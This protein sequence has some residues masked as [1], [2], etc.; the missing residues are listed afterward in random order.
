M[1]A[2]I[3]KIAGFFAV[4]VVLCILAVMAKPFYIVN[5]GEQVVISRLKSIVAS[6]TEAGLYFK[7]PFLDKVTVYPKQILSLDGDTQEIQTKEKL[8]IVVDITARWRITDPQ[9]FYQKFQ[10]LE[11]GYNKLS[12]IIDSSCRTIITQNE[13]SEI[14]RSSDIINEKTDDEEADSETEIVTEET[15]YDTVTKGRNELCRQML[16]EANKTSA[17]MGIEII[18]IVPRQIKYTDALTESVYSRM[19]KERNQE[20]QHY[21]STGEGKKAEWLG[22]L[23]NDK[24]TYES[25]AYRK[26]EEIKGNADAEAAKIYAEA[27]NKDPEFYTFWKSMESYKKTLKDYDATYST[28]MDYFDYLYSANGR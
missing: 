26:A 23:E 21:R 16:S 3:K 17:G 20:A 11:N 10:R 27:F 19:I 4:V 25:E 15:I 6:H 7:V 2:K 22:K 24:R 14:V 8:L 18:D 9:K 5:E 13:L 28:D 1:A 12:D